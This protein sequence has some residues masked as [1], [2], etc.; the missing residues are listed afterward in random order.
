MAIFRKVLSVGAGAL[1]AGLVIAGVEAAGH[2]LAQDE[3]VFAIAMVGYG[4]GAGTGSFIAALVA[5][6]TCAAIVTGILAVLATINLFAFPHPLWFA[7]TAVIVLLLGWAVGSTAA[8]V[9][10]PTGNQGQ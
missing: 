8:G 7:P 3:A 9:R 5:D 2:S 1:A 10:R 6:R 4:L